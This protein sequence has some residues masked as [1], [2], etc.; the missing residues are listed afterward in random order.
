MFRS[1]PLS[2]RASVYLS[3]V[4]NSKTGLFLRMGFCGLLVYPLNNPRQFLDT[5][6]S[7]SSLGV[8][9]MA[10]SWLQCI[11]SE[12]V[13]EFARSSCASTFFN[14]LLERL[15]VVAGWLQVNFELSCNLVFP[16]IALYSLYGCR[17]ASKYL[18]KSSKIYKRE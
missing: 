4:R 3:E 12:F 16:Y 18:V 17:V 9:L 7:R 2:S 6:S 13:S 14:R 8:V 15:Q 5:S 1:V 11:P 10:S